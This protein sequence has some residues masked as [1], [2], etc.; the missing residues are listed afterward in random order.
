MTRAH[1]L[2]DAG[3]SC[4]PL[5]PRRVRARLA[6]A[7]L[8]ALL[9]ASPVSAE[10]PAVTQVEVSREQYYEWT[11]GLSWSKGNY[12]AKAEARLRE[13][14]DFV[15]RACELTDS[16]RLKLELAG[17][18]DIH[19][20]FEKFDQYTATLPSGTVSVDETK[21][22]RRL[23]F[24]CAYGIRYDAGLHGRSSMLRKSLRSTLDERQL[25]AFETALSARREDRY[26]QGVTSTFRGLSQSRIKVSLMPEQLER[27]ADLLL[28]NTESPD[29]E[30]GNS[31]F[32]GHYVLHA[33]SHV[34]QEELRAIVGEEQWPSLS[35]YVEHGRTYADVLQKVAE[36][37]D[38]TP[39]PVANR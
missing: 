39:T 37:G 38:E 34:P 26:R 12:P 4:P 33:L 10:D 9:S 15:Q 24:P 3:S 18:G 21:A 35:A 36:L 5:L 22:L 29:S 23:L 1:P 28:Q 7:S 19:R 25:A 30:V 20:F 31:Y 14:L 13:E 8:V 6:L 16:Q 32:L 2:L 27:V 17:R 11:F